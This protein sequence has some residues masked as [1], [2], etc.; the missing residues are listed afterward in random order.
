V[1][2]GWGYVG[3]LNHDELCGLT[4]WKG[5]KVLHVNYLAWD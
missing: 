1:L 2:G 3:R 4:K 5:E